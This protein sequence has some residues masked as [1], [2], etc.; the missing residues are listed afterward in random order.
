MQ[1]DLKT[2]KPTLGNII[3]GLSVHCI[4]PIAVRMVYEVASVVNIPIIGMG[5]VSS[6]N[7]VLE[8]LMAGARVVA[9]GTSLFTNPNLVR[10]IKTGL[11]EYCQHHQINNISEIIG[12]SHQK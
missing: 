1:I 7:D 4:K 5:G 6:T 2:K 3:G 11:L 10:E 9:V 8:F 12:I